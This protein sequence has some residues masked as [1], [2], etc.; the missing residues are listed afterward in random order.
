MNWAMSVQGP[1]I[2][3]TCFEDV[4]ESP[5][6]PDFVCPKCGTQNG[7]LQPAQAPPVKSAA[8]S[9]EAAASKPTELARSLGSAFGIADHDK[10]TDGSSPSKTTEQVAYPPFLESLRRAGP[11]IL[12][13][14]GIALAIEGFL[15]L[16]QAESVM[17]QT[18]AAI[19]YCTGFVLVALAFVLDALRPIRKTDLTPETHVPCPDCA[20]LIRKE[21]RVCKHCGARLGGSVSRD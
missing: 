10:H 8:P 7:P 12:C 14:A 21:A 9:V 19:N 13:L 18:Y 3:R 4:P 20:E 1:V 6:N 15:I 16:G 17:H 11:I 5:S 2:C